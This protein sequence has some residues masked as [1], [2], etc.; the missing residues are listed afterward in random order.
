MAMTGN[1]A[2]T[3]EQ[4]E[5]EASPAFV[6]SAVALPALPALPKTV[7]ET[8]LDRLL[9]LEL[10]AKT[11]ALF[12]K[13]HLP[14]LAA[15]L[16][17]SINVLNEVLAFMVAE[18]IAQVVRRGASDVDVEYQLTEAGKQRAG[19][20]MARCRYV[21]PAPVTLDAYQAMVERQSVRLNRVTQQDM[22]FA[23]ANLTVNP[24]VRDQIGAAM[25]SGRPLFIYGPP[26]SG[27]TYL[28]ERLGRL[29]QGLVAVPHAIVV[30]NEIIQVFDPLAHEVVQTEPAGGSLDRKTSDGRWLICRRPIVITGGE[31][32]L[33]M[34]ELR[35]DENAGFYQAPPHFK[36]NGG[37]F[38]VDDLGRQQM[39][40]KDLMNR[41]I[42]P[43]DRGRD[44]F[45]LHTGYK[46]TVPFDVLVVFSS[47]LR[48]ESLADDAFM[49]RL[50]Y[51]IHVGAL[52]EDEYRCVLRQHGNSVGIDYDEA[53][54]RYL[55]DELHAKSGHP[56]LA[57][58]PRDLLGQVVDYARYRN[59]RPAMTAQALKQAWGTYF[60]K[61][62]A[63]F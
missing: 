53:A 47:N 35:Y 39:A 36:A 52:S 1:A 37:I 34:L 61:R 43:L 63:A 57:C 10:V 11:V 7:S 9:I 46:F 15:R 28:A 60:A 18:H 12:G 42:V 33:P 6:Q 55:V 38:I 59:E 24:D 32:T 48:P 3:D 21:G 8:G 26:G 13:I 17:L 62:D 51:K 49:R 5:L 25:N 41:W 20:F 19:E 54:F 23:F 27:K 44:H 4:E 31:L 50:G 56:M 29:M 2:T 16:K 45:S 14:M 22:A 30:E 40:P 58:Y